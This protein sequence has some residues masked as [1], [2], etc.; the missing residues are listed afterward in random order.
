MRR[1][2]ITLTTDFGLKDPYVAE[3]KAVILSL[4]R[5]V[6]IVDVT[7]QIKKFDIRMGAYVLASASPYFTKGTTHVAVV[8]PGVGTTRDAIIVQT[9]DGYLVGPN[10]G[11]L[12][13]AAKNA[14]G[15]KCIYKITNKK[16]LPAKVSN[17]FHGRDVFAP[18]AAH[19]ASGKLPGEFGLR[20]KEMVTPKFAKIVK[21]KDKIIGEVIHVD[22]FGNIITNFSRKY[23][24][25]I[26]SEQ[27]IDIKLKNTR[28]R[29]KLTKAY[30]EVKSKKPLALL[31]SHNFLEISINQGNAAEF[32]RTKSGD[33]VILYLSQTSNDD[34]QTPDSRSAEASKPQQNPRRARS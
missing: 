3:M 24:Q 22:D 18:C 10:N 17:T 32:F 29:Y 26:R 31:G 4:C 30:G 12:A 7:H 11:V 13:L 8:D 1:P 27:K 2:I 21:E 28:L 25:H 14:P 33:R 20:I 15:P 9:G 16:F 23:F 6:V 19:L 34:Q 5:N